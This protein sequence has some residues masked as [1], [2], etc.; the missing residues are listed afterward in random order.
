[1]RAAEAAASG[2]KRLELGPSHVA[3]TVSL[4]LSSNVNTLPA[5]RRSRPRRQSRQPCTNKRAQ[6]TSPSNYTDSLIYKQLERKALKDALIG[7]GGVSSDTSRAVGCCRRLESDSNVR[8]RGGSAAAAP[9]TSSS[10]ATASMSA[11]R[12]AFN[13]SGGLGWEAARRHGVPCDDRRR[14]PDE[15]AR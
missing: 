15:K 1:V 13:C 6:T 2:V 11:D 3:P 4:F 12:A 9:A 8:G 5:Q 10:R 7:V 14:R